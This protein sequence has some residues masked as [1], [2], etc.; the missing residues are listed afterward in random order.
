LQVDKTSQ[1]DHEAAD[2]KHPPSVDRILVRRKAAERPLPQPLNIALRLR[3]RRFG[4]GSGFRKIRI[5][6]GISLSGIERRATLST[7][8]VSQ[9]IL[10]PAAR[11]GYFLKLSGLGKTFAAGGFSFQSPQGFAP[12]FLQKLADCLFAFGRRSAKVHLGPA[13]KIPLQRR[14]GQR[15]QFRAG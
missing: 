11:A 1:D 3:G 7:E 6:C 13:A 15:V 8:L 2:G 10:L 4:S 12:D 14:I 5:A 9:G